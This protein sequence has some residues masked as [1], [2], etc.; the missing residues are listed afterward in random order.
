MKK[1]IAVVLVGVMLNGCGNKESAQAKIIEPAPKLD[2][3]Y[4]MKDGYEYGYEQAI[5]A[6]QQNA[7]QAATT[8]MMFKYVGQK[9]GMH[10]AYSKGADGAITVAQCSNPCDFIKVMVFYQGEYLRTERMKATDGTVGW[11]VMADAING[12]LEQYV[13]DRNGKKMH[14]WFDEKNGVITTPVINK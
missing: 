6:D 1:L 13:A 5:S 12:K 10:Q 7:G 14:I 9:N 3:G 2:H 11:M 8:L 4:S